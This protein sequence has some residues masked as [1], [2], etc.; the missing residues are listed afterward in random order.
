M[1]DRKACI[2]VLSLNQGHRFANLSIFPVMGKSLLVSEHPL[3]LL[4]QKFGSVPRKQVEY[5][6]P[7]S[8]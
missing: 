4:I 6:L 8:R 3:L 7:S 5:L 1:L 2:K